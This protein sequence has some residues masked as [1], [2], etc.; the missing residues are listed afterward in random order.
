MLYRACVH[1]P[2]FLTRFPASTRLLQGLSDGHVKDVT[3][4]VILSARQLL[5]ILKHVVI[6]KRKL[7]QLDDAQLHDFE[8]ELND[9]M[10]DI[11]L[12][13]ATIVKVK[14]LRA[15]VLS[16]EA[17]EF[18]PGVGAAAPPPVVYKN[19]ILYA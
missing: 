8:Y 7:D 19:V 9:V 5:G 4:Y 2:P 15:H 13:R 6:L 10:S 12:I 11:K 18:V 17:A 14:T 3:E 1:P 16:A